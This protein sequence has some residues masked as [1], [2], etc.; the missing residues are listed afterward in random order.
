MIDG[1]P[2]ARFTQG[3]KDLI[4]SGYDLDYSTVESEQVVAAGIAKKN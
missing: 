3:L 4:E 1:T 2:A